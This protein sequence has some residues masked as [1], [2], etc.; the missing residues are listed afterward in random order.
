[1]S[2]AL[3]RSWSMW[4]APGWQ[5]PRVEE[6]SAWLGAMGLQREWEPGAESVV[7]SCWGLTWQRWSMWSMIH[8]RYPTGKC[9]AHRIPPT[10]STSGNDHLSSQPLSGSHKYPKAEG[11]HFQ[12]TISLSSPPWSKYFPSKEPEA[13]RHSKISMTTFCSLPVLTSGFYRMLSFGFIHKL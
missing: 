9:R 5:Q 3:E 6:G 11:S 13:L 2:M 7:G 1:M 12:H 10:L 4:R 8:P